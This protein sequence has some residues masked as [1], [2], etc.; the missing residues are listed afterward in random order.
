MM[1]LKAQLAISLIEKWGLVA[2]K[3]EGETSNG[4]NRLLVMTPK[5]MVGR[6]MDT[7]ERA[8]DDM[9]AMGWMKEGEEE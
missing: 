4:G 6:A 3:V 2:S 7:A 5:E 1:N 8:V 9:M